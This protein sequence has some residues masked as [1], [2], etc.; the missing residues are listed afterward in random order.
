MTADIVRGVPN[1]MTSYWFR[2]T[3]W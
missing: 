3:R 1:Q 2:R